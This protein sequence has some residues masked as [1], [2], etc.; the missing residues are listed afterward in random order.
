MPDFKI[1]DRIK[2]S[3]EGEVHSVDSA[4]N[5]FVK[6]QD[7]YTQRFY[8]PSASTGHITVEVIEPEYEHGA[9]YMDADGDVFRWTA[10]DNFPWKSFAGDRFPRDYPTKPIQKMVP[11]K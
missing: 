3:F 11:E 2:V 1:G 8:A 4:G 5:V 7:D 6:S 9:I 10:T